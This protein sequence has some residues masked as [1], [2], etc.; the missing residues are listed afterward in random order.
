MG[1]TWPRGA[2]WPSGQIRVGAAWIREVLGGF[3]VLPCCVLCSSPPCPPTPLT[4]AWS[5]P[6]ALC[7][8][9]S[10]AYRTQVPR[11]ERPWA[12]VLHTKQLQ[13]PRRAEGSQ[14]LSSGGGSGWGP[15]SPLQAH[16]GSPQGA[17]LL[18]LCALPWRAWGCPCPLPGL[19]PPCGTK[20]TPAAPPPSPLGASFVAAS[21]GGCAPDCWA[22]LTPP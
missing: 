12:L 4:A 7:P 11:T 15:C 18:V 5:L 22:L 9:G 1:P 8:H 20:A 16:S 10:A 21:T 2:R 19:C 14:V 6:G 17:P 13:K 3:C